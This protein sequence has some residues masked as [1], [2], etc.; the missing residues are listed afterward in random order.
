MLHKQEVETM[1]KPPRKGAP[2]RRRLN[3][4]DSDIR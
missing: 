4:E 2:W 3:N 1:L